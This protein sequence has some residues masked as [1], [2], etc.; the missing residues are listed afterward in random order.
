M[1]SIKTIKMVHIKKKKK[2]LKKRKKPRGSLQERELKPIRTFPMQSPRP[3][4][5]SWYWRL[6]RME[7]ECMAPG[8]KL[9]S[10]QL[11]HLMAV[12]P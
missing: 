3:V 10:S 8:T 9:V 4:C 12:K 6:Y 1:N 11:P 7:N 5:S 2:F